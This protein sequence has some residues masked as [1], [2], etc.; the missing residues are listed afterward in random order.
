M[1]RTLKGVREGKT[2][3]FA[4][5]LLA[6]PCMAQRNANNWQLKQEADR[7]ISKAYAPYRQWSDGLVSYFGKTVYQRLEIIPVVPTQWPGQAG[8][9]IVILSRGYE[10]LDVTDD[11]CRIQPLK[12]DDEG[13][14]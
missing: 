12:G 4:V 5:C 9:G 10:V 6:F 13:F 8:T 14:D 7:I 2:I 1:K 11:G 3:F